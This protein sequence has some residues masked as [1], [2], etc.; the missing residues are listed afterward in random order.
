MTFAMGGISCAGSRQADNKTFFFKL[1]TRITYLVQTE[2]VVVLES[3][4]GFSLTPPFI[5]ST[6]CKA[7]HLPELQLP[8]L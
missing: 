5:R 3:V 1:R 4:L 7:L 6:L 8:H 2:L